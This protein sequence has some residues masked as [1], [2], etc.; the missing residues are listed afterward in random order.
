MGAS[1][2]GAGTNTITISGVASLHSTDY[3]IIPDRV[4]AGTFLVA[5]AITHSELSLSPIVPE[6][7]MAVIAKLQS[8]G[9]QTIADAPNTLR[10]IPGAKS[11]G[12]RY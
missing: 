9:V 4:E 10:I 7:L 2:R 12:N 5:G 1:I 6:H 8:M 11:N 3:K